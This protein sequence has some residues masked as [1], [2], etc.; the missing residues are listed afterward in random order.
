[1]EKVTL[2]K[3]NCVVEVVGRGRGIMGT[4]DPTLKLPKGRGYAP[5]GM[6]KG[7][8]SLKFFVSRKYVFYMH[9]CVHIIKQCCDFVMDLNYC[10]HTFYTWFIFIPSSLSQK[11]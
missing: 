11:I 3:L 9:V 7:Q 5:P 8:H 2:N 4:V 10:S 6:G 1:M